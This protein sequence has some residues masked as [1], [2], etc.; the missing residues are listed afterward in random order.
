LKCL[1]AWKRL[2][3]K[4]ENKLYAITLDMIDFKL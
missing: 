4:S 2:I 1:P 3:S